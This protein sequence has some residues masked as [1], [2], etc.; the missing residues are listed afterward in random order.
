MC[1]VGG[2][3]IRAKASERSQPSSTYRQP[4]LY[5]ADGK[6][7]DQRLDERF[8]GLV[9]MHGTKVSNMLVSAC[10]LPSSSVP[11]SAIGW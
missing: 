11:A 10:D 5:L 9:G 6:R 4:C 8:T 3:V 1:Y 2:G 7:G